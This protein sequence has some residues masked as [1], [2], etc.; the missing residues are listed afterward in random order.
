MQVA[1]AEPSERL[2]RAQAATAT[3]VGLAQQQ[4]PQLL[5]RLYRERVPAILARAGS[6]TTV[7]KDDAGHMILQGPAQ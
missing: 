1:Q 5:L 2:S 4:D 6:V 3:I 7:N